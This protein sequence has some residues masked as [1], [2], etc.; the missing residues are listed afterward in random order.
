MLLTA[1]SRCLQ[2]RRLQSREA[3]SPQ[4]NQ[5]HRHLLAS[6]GSQ[7]LLFEFSEPVVGFTK[8]SVYVQNGKVQVNLQCCPNMLS[9][10]LVLPCMPL[11]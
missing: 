11:F 3:A 6:S 2:G 5:A 9:S 4:R 10:P 8:D 1:L 7:T